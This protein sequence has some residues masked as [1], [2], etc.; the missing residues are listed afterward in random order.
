MRGSNRWAVALLACALPAQGETADPS[1]GACPAH[2]F[3]IARSKNANIVAYDAQ[4]GP[5][6][7]LANSEPV[8]AYWLLDGDAG[9]REELNR[10]ERERGYGVD[11]T[12]GDA[13]GTYVVAFKADRKRR[14]ALRIR[15]GCP[16]AV[17]P[18]GGQDGILRRLFVR[19]KEGTFPPGVEYIEFFGEDVTSG[20]PLYEKFVPAK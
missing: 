17:T 7:D 15:D 5:T 20:A 14:L 1:G 12:P 4:R 11:V 9:K 13:P 2:I 3:V 19:S 8:V 6:G 18:I 16:I 10:V